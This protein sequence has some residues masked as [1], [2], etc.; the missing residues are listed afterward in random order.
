[1]PVR[2][3]ADLVDRAVMARVALEILSRVRSTALV[4]RAVFSGHKVVVSHCTTSREVYRKTTSFGERHAALFLLDFGASVHVFL[5]RVGVTFEL[6]EFI[7][8]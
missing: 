8:L 7:K 6:F 5:V 4:D 2:V 1:M 3:A